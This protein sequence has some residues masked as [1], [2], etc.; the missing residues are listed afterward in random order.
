MCPSHPR[1]VSTR[2]EVIAYS[3]VTDVSALVRRVVHEC[4]F[5]PIC[6]LTRSED[7]VSPQ[8]CDFLAHIPEAQLLYR[9]S[10]NQRFILLHSHRS[11]ASVLRFRTHVLWQHSIPECIG[12]THSHYLSNNTHCVG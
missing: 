11:V 1:M 6:I 12:R 10:A 2:V 7:S 5:V 3:G 8:Q 9:C 4:L